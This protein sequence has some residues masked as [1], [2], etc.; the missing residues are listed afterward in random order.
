ML[1]HW[2]THPLMRGTDLDDP[3]T[4]DLR[5]RLVLERD[6]LRLIYHEWYGLLAQHVRPDL[7]PTVELGWGGGFGENVIED[8]IVSEVFYHHTVDVVLDGQEVP[9]RDESLGS[10]LLINV[11]HHLPKV[12]RFFADAARCV[13]SGGVVAMIEPWST[14]WSL[15]VYKCLHHEPFDVDAQKWEFPYT[16]PLSSSNNALAWVVFGRDRDMFNEEF[17]EWEVTCVWPFMPVRYVLSGGVSC[18]FAMPGWSFGF[19]RRVEKC[20]QPLFRHL[21][22]FALVVVRRRPR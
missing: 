7:G 14:P 9:F 8:L 20:L 1:R 17:P 4:T 13:R 21:A 6:F 11:F 15:L 16:G 5:H 2:L 10:L 3:S 12:R 18:R 22:M 19:W